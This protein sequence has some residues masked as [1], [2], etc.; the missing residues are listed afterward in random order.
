MQEVIVGVAAAFIGIFI[1]YLLRG[2]SAKAHADQLDRRAQELTL[3]LATVRSEREK[4]QDESSRRAGFESVAAEREKTITQL[5]AERDRLQEGMQAKSDIETKSFSQIRQLETE[6]R[7]ER[8]SLAEKLALLETAKQALANQFEALAADIL[9]KKS[10][11]FAEGSQKELGTLLNPLRD[12]IKDFREKVEKAQSDSNTGVAELRGMIGNLDSLNKALA[13][14]ARNLTMALRGSAKHQGD[15]GEFILRDLLEKAGL[16]EGEQYT[17]QQSFTGVESDNGERARTVRTDVILNLPGGR[18]LVVD[19]KVSL[20]A[21]TD[22]TSATEDEARRIALKLHLTSMRGHVSGLAK[23][24]YHRLT[25]VE[26]PDF[27]VMF[28]PVE[29]AFLMALQHDGDLWSEAY[30]QGILLVGPTTLLYV[31]RII[32]LLWAQQQQSKNVDEVMKR[33]GDLYDKFVNFVADL[34]DVGKNLRNAETS[35]T[36]A[37]SKLSEGRG[38]LVRQVE[39]LRRLKVTT[40]KQLSPSLLNAA[41]VDA[42]EDDDPILALAAQADDPLQAE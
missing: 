35:W 14:E 24:G 36:G 29:P 22:C 15:W 28:V 19:S 41:H 34:E 18:H 20:T 17:F 10:K 31:I 5:A 13:E 23:A 11:S 42:V 37:M 33:G 38:N 39:M 25:G 4:A 1:G 3:E 27:V 30:K 2:S 8:E 9:D 32:D 40:K 16:R 21:Y 6:L 26:G 7:K 12:Q